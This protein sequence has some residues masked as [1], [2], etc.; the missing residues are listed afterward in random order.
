MYLLIIG[1]PR[2]GTTLLASMIGSHSNVAM[3]IEDRFFSIKK[4]TGKKILAN[5]LC[6]PIQLELT[7]KAN[8][9]TRAVQ[10]IGLLKNISV[11]RFNSED[12]LSLKDS[13]IIAIIRDGDHVVRS[14]M[15]RGEKE[16]K[17]ATGR[18][19]RAIQIISELYKKNPDKTLV[20]SYEDLVKEPEKLLGKI[21]AFLQIEFERE[22]LEGYKHNILYP[23]ESGIDKSR[24]FQS[25]HKVIDSETSNHQLAIN[26][27]YNKLLEV[28][29]KP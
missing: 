16:K 5:K 3:L 17:I 23:G 26:E 14:I 25:Q 11:S 27:L 24:A 28:K 6:I 7:Q 13:K 18:W 29:T 12:Y 2:S 15:K 8:Y 20:I 4:L 1:A 9:F 19:N 22:M 21:C 10:K